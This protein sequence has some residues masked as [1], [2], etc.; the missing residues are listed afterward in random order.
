MSVEQTDLTIETIDENKDVGLAGIEAYSW[1]I[2]SQALRV[3]EIIKGFRTCLPK[4]HTE[5]MIGGNIVTVVV[6]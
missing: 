4:K 1:A 3:L 5:I 6:F 2:S